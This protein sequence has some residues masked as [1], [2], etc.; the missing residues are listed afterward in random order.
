LSLTSA[1]ESLKRRFGHR[2]TLTRGN[3]TVA[4]TACLHR[5]SEKNLAGSATLNTPTYHL[6]ASEVA[7][8]VLGI[9]KTKDKITD[10]QTIK[11]VNKVEE[12][13]AADAGGLVIGWRLRT[14]G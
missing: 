5:D 8:T 4:V 3:V 2:I 13:L 9:P 11:T 14:G 10:G 7:G 6:I 1:H 12:I